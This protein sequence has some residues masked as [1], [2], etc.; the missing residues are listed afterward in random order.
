MPGNFLQIIVM[1]I[2]YVEK[3]RTI[4]QDAEDN[5]IWRMRF[6]CWITKGTDRQTDTHTHTHRIYNTS[7]FAWKQWFREGASMLH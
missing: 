4:R 1:F 2:R 6:A 7:C 3:C 5:K